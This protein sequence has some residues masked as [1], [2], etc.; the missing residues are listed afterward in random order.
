[1]SN[2]NRR[3]FVSLMGLT[4]SGLLMLPSGC[5]AKSG[6]PSASNATTAASAEE[7][8]G[9]FASPSL[10]CG[11]WVYWFWMGGNI[12]R[13]GVT[14]D[15]EAMRRV[16]IGG[17][18]IMNVSTDPGGSYEMGVPPG[19]VK[20]GT[21]EWREM[22][23]FACRE[24]ARLGLQINMTNDAGWEGSGGP[25]VTPER[26][27]QR[28]VYT[29]T[30][31]H[32]GTTIDVLLPQPKP[33]VRHNPPFPT[34]ADT[35][36][37]LQAVLDY[38]ADIAV[39]AFPTPQADM[40][41]HGYRIPD[42]QAKAE[43]VVQDNMP[44]QINYPQLP[45]GQAIP[46][47]GLVDVSRFMDS[48]G[49][50]KWEAP[51]GDWTIIRFGHTSTGRDNH[52]ASVS[53]SGLEIDKLSRKATELQFNSL[54]LRLI[55]DVG[56]LAGKSFVR[57]HIDSWE[58]GSQ[59]WTLE[60]PREF[61]RLRGYDIAPY[62]P[63]LAGR[64]VENLE[65]SNRFLWDFR[66]T[67]SDL[68]VENYAACMRE[69]A[70]KH[71]IGLSIEGYAGVPADELRYGGQANEPMS[72]LWSWPRWN[73]WNI[74][75]EMTSA[76]HVY[77]R[78]IIGQE[79]FT[80]GPSEKWQAYPAVV[81]DIGDWAFGEGVNRFVFHRFAMQPWTNPHYAPGMSMDSTG[82][83]YERTETWWHLTKPWHDYVSR[84]SYLLRQGHF[85]A[86]VCY[87]QA[88]GAPQEFATLD[89]GPGNPPRRPGYNYDF[90]PAEVV[91]TRMEY[92][93][94]FLTLPS[95]MKYRV[96]VLPDSPTMTPQLL[97]KIK[98][99]VDAGAT[100]IG[101]QPQKSPSLS[102]FP[103]CDDQVQKLTGELWSTGKI[104][105]G[106]TAAQVLAAKG[107]KPDFQCDHP[108]V[109]WTHR[110]TADMDIY[111]V[112]N[113]E[114]A[115]K[116]PFAGKSM[117][118]NCAF[119][120]TGIQPEFWDP[121]TGT[122]SP[123]P[124]YES[125]GGMTHIPIVFEPKGSAFVVF[126]H[127]K[128]AQITEAIRSIS[129][130]GKLLFAASVAPPPHIKI[131]SASYGVPGNA[132]HTR[133]VTAIVQK[134]VNQGQ[135]DFPVMQIA[136][137]GGDPDPGV[138]K[139]LDIHYTVNGHEGHISYQDG[140]RVH[141]NLTPGSHIKILSASYG[142]PG[143][144]VHTRNVTAI[145]Q[146]LV[147]QGDTDFPVMQ[148]VVIGGD[149]D[150]GVVKTL[151]IHYEADGRKGHISSQ[152]GGWASFAGAGP[153]YRRIVELEAENNGRLKAIVTEPGKYDCM[154]ASGKQSTINVADIPKPVA[155]EGSW[156]VK[157][158]AGW[159]APAEIHLDKLIAW[160]K[161]HDV[162]VRYFSGTA[163]YQTE[164]KIP[165]GLLTPDQ[166]IYL[167]LGEVAVMAHVTL[168]NHDLG[169]LWKP[170]FRLDATAALRSGRNQL[171]IRVTN[172]WINRMIGDEQLP[173][174]SDR[175]PG[176]N[177][178]KW[179]QWLLEGKPSPTGRFTFTT[180]QHWHKTDPLVESGLIGPVNLTFADAVELK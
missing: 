14:A 46:Q 158:P 168:N 52:P 164:F 11:P 127:G 84:C 51:A 80:A 129:H 126:R 115:D 37:Q 81:K 74:V 34:A 5:A 101:P 47:S 2:L 162:G 166:R 109:R 61:R 50:L 118:A 96:L 98:T 63:V 155:I 136:A 174:D 112:A 123:V 130:N 72:E 105:A 95:G 116:L 19:P 179:P 57:T 145:V 53:G 148:M 146:K 117:L 151:D 124:A 28:V 32:G 3:D 107:I 43:Y 108:M 180:W 65:V 144:A 125:S 119:R 102:D 29:T 150:P 45:L 56:P 49:R 176:G 91:L 161:H 104:I 73:A 153:A 41:G 139:T 20:F 18:L 6:T 159:G 40:A 85:V 27:M 48:Y 69:L 54:I 171:N 64:V 93:G 70:N 138:V 86:D 77:G 92:K 87:M 39:L 157:F 172:L 10:D 36:V 38:Y 97:K 173:E 90:C 135:T 89:N 160:N 31:L 94:G 59:N 175:G 147:N 110:H 133:D 26:S 121:E 1:M 33:I 113:G 60:F 9:K 58:N 128:S 13:E 44:T 140:Q 167:D 66:R 21:V 22:F 142:V 122:I 111:F 4:A 88:E 152:D 68:L 67:I 55:R 76:G 8:A 156:K 169:I 143:D 120:V 132:A 35:G 103:H 154:F 79:T 99:L 114:V 82:M 17:A 62:L 131:L 106:K 178:L 42:I 141:I 25:W 24:A 12:T 30:R 23:A 149:P 137:I 75:A 163:E 15:L 100:V 78:N 83:H 165:A 177:L 170:P 7:V 134:L 16:G 71:G